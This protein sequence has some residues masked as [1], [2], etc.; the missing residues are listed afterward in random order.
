VNFNAIAFGFCVSML[1]AGCN[2][3]T[4]ANVRKEVA[5]DHQKLFGL[6][7]KTALVT[8]ASSGLGLA[9]SE[10]LAQAGARVIL[11]ARK[12][13]KVQNAVNNLRAKSLDAV[14]IEMDVS[15]EDSVKTALSLLEAK[16]EK[17]DILV[18]NAALGMATPIFQPDSQHDF[19]KVIKTNLI[20]VWY[21]TKAVANH[22]KLNNIQGSI[23]NIASVNGETYPYKNQ[24]AYAVSKAA[25]IHMTKSLVLELSP[26]KIR[27]NTIS[28][29]PIKSYL[30]GAPFEH[31][32][33][34]WRGKI[35]LGFLAEPSDLFGALIYLASNDASRF[36]T[37]SCIT[38]DGGLSF[39]E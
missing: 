26:Y 32:W 30:Y 9:F 5:V 34:F 13:D 2:V 29:G 39:H 28:P 10:A 6:H 38:I 27:I 11:S 14:A 19:E 33:S 8:G 21:V 16:G 15:Q 12:L 25:I 23:I 37:G 31:D 4:G 35:P 7:R 20:G 36:M 17:I 24:T 1:L 18:N 3:S 22:M